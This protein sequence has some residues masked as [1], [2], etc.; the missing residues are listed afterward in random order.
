MRPSPPDE[1][2]LSAW[3]FYSFCNFFA[4]LQKGCVIQVVNYRNCNIEMQKCV[5]CNTVTETVLQIL[6]Y[7][8]RYR[9]CKL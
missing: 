6:Y 1:I 7:S 3:T 2:S 9:K 4:I 5:L 8:Y